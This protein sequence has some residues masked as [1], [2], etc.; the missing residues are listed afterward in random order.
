M[1]IIMVGLWVGGESGWPKHNFLE[2]V[3]YTSAF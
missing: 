2:F 1:V 3:V